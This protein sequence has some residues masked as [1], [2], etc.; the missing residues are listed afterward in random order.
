LFI[1]KYRPRAALAL[2]LWAV[3]VGVAHAQAVN[4]QSY[5]FVD[6]GFSASF[7]AKPKDLQRTAPSPAGPLEYHFHMLTLPS[8]ALIVSVLELPKTSKPS[9][10]PQVLQDGVD[11]SLKSSNSR[12][13]HQNKIVMAGHPGIEYEAENATM[14]FST[15]TFLVGTKSYS[16]C[17]T[18]S[19]SIPYIETKRFLDSF[20]LLPAGDR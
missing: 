17:V 6:D 7:P 15:R 19:A 4:W 18:S 1:R 2:V 5:T 12:L 8:G 13:L 11:G 16:A 10:A 9:D 14:H 3:C 20:R